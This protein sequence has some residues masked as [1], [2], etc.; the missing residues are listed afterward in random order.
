MK[1]N[2]LDCSLRD[3]GYYN[4]WNFNI[5]F[6]NKYLNLLSKSNIEYVEIGFKSLINE[7]KIGL[8][9]KCENFFL[10]KLRVPKN[11][12]LGVMINVSDFIIK[13]IN[14]SD[15]FKQRSDKIKFVRLATHVGDIL[16]IGKAI[17]WL[18]NNGYIVAVNIMQISEIKLNQIKIYCDYLKKMNVDILYFA[19]S[20][21][22]LKPNN[23]KKISRVFKKNWN[24]DIGIHAHDNLGLALK[25]SEVAY[26]NG[27]SWIDSTI[28]GMG[29]G[30]GNT[31]TESLISNILKYKFN[32]YHYKKVEKDLIILFKTL[33]KKYQWGTNKYY[34]YSGIK[35]IHPTYIQEILANKN[36]SKK[37][38]S[39]MIKGLTKLNA[40]KYNPLNMYFIDNFLK[41][42]S[43]TE[44]VPKNI[45]SNKKILIIGPGN[46][47]YNRKKVIQNFII[48][49]KLTVLYT[50]KV[51]NI[52][53]IKDYFRIACHPLRLLTDSIF[54][55]KKKDTLI[56]PVTNVPQKIL[57]EFKKKNKKILNFGL[58]FNKKQTIKIGKSNCNLPEPLII[59]YSLCFAI[60]AGIKKIYI[61]GFDGFKKDDPYTDTTQSMINIFKKKL[62]I[63]YITS[64]TKTDYK[65]K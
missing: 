62:K 34:Y 9:G 10:D 15:F 48:K 50:N 17:I 19:D 8:T 13:P 39:L 46:T 22:C 61:A 25:N 20:Y 43:Y 41:K 56:I 57:N 4:N 55:I 36:N 2:I 24:G 31:K 63:N 18:K 21:G 3:G 44:I 6:V 12:N 54:H 51:P 58:K 11:V 65:F 49:E 7:K 33:K 37:E 1:L 26:R 42:N 47:I 27:V 38:I 59:G 52:F 5:S 29:R 30:P 60:S 53:N 32:N 35:K 45:L 64:L 40:K 28:L 14:I 23:I 16:K